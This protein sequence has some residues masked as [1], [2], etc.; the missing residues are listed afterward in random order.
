MVV[1]AMCACGDDDAPADDA[2][3]PTCEEQ[4]EALDAFVAANQACEIA[5]DCAIAGFIRRD[6][7]WGTDF[8]VT[9]HDDAE[10]EAQRLLDAMQSCLPATVDDFDEPIAS[11]EDG[12]CRIVGERRTSCFPVPPDAGTDAGPADA[13]PDAG[14]HDAA[15]GA[16]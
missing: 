7:D 2:R 5:A 9:V 4:R 13:G 14:A 15:T 10:G 1:L 8:V 16:D 11:C 6:C 12:R 3:V